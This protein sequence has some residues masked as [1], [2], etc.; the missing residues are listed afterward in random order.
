MGLGV[1]WP[2]LTLWGLRGLLAFERTRCSEGEPVE[3]RLALRNRLPWT[4]WGLALLAGLVRAGRS[5]PWAAGLAAAFAAVLAL[6]VQTDVIGDPW[7][8]YCVWG[9]AGALTL[10]ARPEVRLASAEAPAVASS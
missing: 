8:A 1:A 10:R 6:A 5:D 4:A 2:W 7:V 9:F 3:V